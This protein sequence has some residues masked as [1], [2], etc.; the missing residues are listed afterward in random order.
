MGILNFGRW[1][2]SNTTYISEYIG[3]SSTYN[4]LIEVNPLIYNA[5][6]VLTAKG[7]YDFGDRVNPNNHMYYLGTLLDNTNLYNIISTMVWKSI[8]Q[9]YNYYKPEKTLVLV[10]DGVPP[11]AKLQQQ[12]SRRYANQNEKQDPNIDISIRRLRERLVHDMITPGTEF[13]KIFNELIIGSISKYKDI[14][15]NVDIIYSPH[16]VEGEGEHKIFDLLRSSNIVSFQDNKYDVVYGVDSD[17]SIIALMLNE[18]Y[19]E[20]DRNIIFSREAVKNH[21]QY[22]VFGDNFKGMFLSVND[23]YKRDT[24]TPTVEDSIDQENHIS[25]KKLRKLLVEREDISV[26]DFAFLIMFIG[27]DFVPKLPS[28]RLPNT[29]V[30]TILEIYRVSEI[31]D[32][33][34][35][36]DDDYNIDWK[37]LLKFLTIYTYNEPYLLQDTLN[38][39]LTYENIKLGLI[40]DVIRENPDVGS[41][42]LFLNGD[43]FKEYRNRWYDNMDTSDN[44]GVRSVDAVCKEYFDGMLWTLHYYT[45]PSKVTKLWF[46]PYYYSPFVRD[47]TRY[48]ND[49]IDSIDSVDSMYDPYLDDL[50]SVEDYVDYHI[51][52]YQQLF[53]VIPPTSY[54]VLPHKFTK[55]E[56]ENLDGMVSRLYVG[57]ID[58][59]RIRGG[60]MAKFYLGSY[61][62]PEIIQI[63]YED[64]IY[65]IRRGEV[66]VMGETPIV[67]FI[68][69]QVIVESLNGFINSSLRGDYSGDVSVIRRRGGVK[70]PIK[71]EAEEVKVSGT[72]KESF[73]LKRKRRQP[74][75]TGKIRGSSLTSKRKGRGRRKKKR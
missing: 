29:R 66:K 38:Q 31:Q 28:A 52:I 48:L 68:D 45:F 62:G 60:N 67:D 43:V 51:D 18:R 34:T 13:M 57:D 21:Y 55:R 6:N 10:L 9:I 54:W 14:W 47:L 58:I 44:S 49:N 37:S 74:R 2:F 35:F 64:A 39:L 17:L 3:G 46:Y 69:L 4:L 15:K 50:L 40:D 59:Y 7:D 19:L 1:L 41:E 11:L 75:G 33:V 20:E 27:N 73:Q 26:Y 25:I 72:K 23:F 5:F 71:D 42:S 61:I 16:T 36:E 32:I 63:Q 22:S 30:T 24:R 56:L 70:S 8:E 53:S 12:R 65:F